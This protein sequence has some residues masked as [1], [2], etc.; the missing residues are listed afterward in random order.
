MMMRRIRARIEDENKFIRFYIAQYI[1]PIIV[2]WL[3]LSACY[4]Q[5]KPNRLIKYVMIKK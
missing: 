2:T 3:S 5:V 1:D 4:A